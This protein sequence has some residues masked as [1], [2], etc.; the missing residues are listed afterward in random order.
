M[1]VLQEGASRYQNGMLLCLL[2]GMQLKLNLVEELHTPQFVTGQP[3][4]PNGA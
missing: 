3:S 2:D 4:A 1:V